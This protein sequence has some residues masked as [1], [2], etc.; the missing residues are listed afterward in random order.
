MPRPVFRAG[1]F[2]PE[3]NV[4]SVLKGSSSPS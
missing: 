2:S 4:Q 3:M 1:H